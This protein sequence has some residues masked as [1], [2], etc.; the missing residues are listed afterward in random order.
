L[1]AEAAQ[2]GGL[3]IISCGMPTNRI[4]ETACDQQALFG[5]WIARNRSAHQR[6]KLRK[7]WAHGVGA[8]QAKYGCSPSVF[9]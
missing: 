6:Q 7:P 8:G 3:G 4:V 1:A 9:Q 5:P 2:D